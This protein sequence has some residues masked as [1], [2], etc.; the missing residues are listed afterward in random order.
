MHPFWTPRIQSRQRDSG[1]P[2][3]VESTPASEGLAAPVLAGRGDRSLSRDRLRSSSHTRGVCSDSSICHGPS[4][5]ARQWCFLSLHRYPSL[6]LTTLTVSYNVSVAMFTVDA[7]PG[8]MVF[9]PGPPAPFPHRYAPL[10]LGCAPPLCGRI[11]LR[12]LVSPGVPGRNQG[13]RQKGSRGGKVA[14]PEGR[15]GQLPCCAS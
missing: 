15:E 11:A 12:P 2:P 5:Q 8:R 7:G 1:C 13:T 10:P 14:L 9:C 6:H 4:V 3:S